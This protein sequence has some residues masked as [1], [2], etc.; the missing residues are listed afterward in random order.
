VEDVAYA[1]AAAAAAAGRYITRQQREK[2]CYGVFTTVGGCRMSRDCHF[3][4]L[5]QNMR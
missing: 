1:D 3:Q 5:V 2:H 4:E